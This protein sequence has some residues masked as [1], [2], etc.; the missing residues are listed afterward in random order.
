MSSQRFSNNLTGRVP[1]L[2][3]TA[4]GIVA[5]LAALVALVLLSP[6][7]ATLGNVVKI[8]YL[9]GALERVATFAYLGAGAL[10]IG[11]LASKR[12]R[13]GAWAQACAEIAILF[14]IAQFVVSLPAQ[15]LAWGGITWDEPRVMSATWIL[16]FTTTIYIVAR[17]MGG[18]VWMSAAAFA[19]ALILG[20][21]LRGAINILHPF[22]PIFGSDSVAIKFF[23]TAM[24]LVTAALAS[25]LAYERA[26]RIRVIETKQRSFSITE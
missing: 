11:Y 21:I 13:L 17:W 25:L 22:N 7:E 20:L 23:Y 26:R 18:T 6:A 5:L 8:V 16:A 19:N 2:S 3:A 14:W 4:L 15:V 9:H 24:V 10:G 1:R 12:E